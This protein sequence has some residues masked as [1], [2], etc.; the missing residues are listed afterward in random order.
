MKVTQLLGFLDQ[1]DSGGAKCSGTP[2]ASDAGDMA[3]Q[4]L[5]LASGSWQSEGLL[6][7]SSVCP[8]HSG[9]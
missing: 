6:S 3:Y 2:P 5:L 8:A 1:G 9:S 7:G 4:N